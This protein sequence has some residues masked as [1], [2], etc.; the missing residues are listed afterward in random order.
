L[1]HSDWVGNA[2]FSPDDSLVI[3]ASRDDTAKIWDAKTGML[4]AGPLRHKN[5]VVS[6]CF[7]P[8]GKWVLTASDDGT[9]RVWD[10]RTGQPVGEAM[11]HDAPVD[12]AEFSP[13]GLRVV[14]ASADRTARIWDSQTGREVA[15][16]LWHRDRVTGAQFNRDGSRVVT[17][18][19]DGTARVWDART[20]QPLSE[21]F[22]HQAI[23][24]CARFNQE[25]SRVVTASLDQTARIW[26]VPIVP[27][28][29]P[30]WF[31]RL[32]EAVAGQRLTREGSSESVQV[33]QLVNIRRQILQSPE[34]NFYVQWGKWFFADRATRG[35]SPFSP[36][37]LPVKLEA[38][39]NEN[40]VESLRAAV[41]LSP[42]NAMTFAAL[43]RKLLADEAMAPPDRMAEAEWLSRFASRLAPHDPEIAEV[44]AR[45]L[46]ACKPSISGTQ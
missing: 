41:A 15:E 10:A 25:G 40:T 26:E 28:P 2:R 32:A 38:L 30:G 42:T 18:C 13:D 8:D 21:P 23:V 20:G 24:T 34:T 46:A 14:T 5:W 31:A 45:I 43:A 37:T 29:V 16:P 22:A 19:R 12:H 6:A 17:A 7:S 11:R 9:A 4:V 27:L 1:R 35:I 44:R 33:E 36:V 3:T 39:I